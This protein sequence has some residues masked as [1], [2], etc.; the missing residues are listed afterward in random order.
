MQ[1]ASV[2]LVLES[3]A[4]SGWDGFWLAQPAPRFSKDCRLTGLRV[5]HRS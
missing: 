5:D 2:G 1:F 4:F 3:S